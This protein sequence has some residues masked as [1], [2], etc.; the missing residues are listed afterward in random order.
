MLVLSAWLNAQTTVRGYVFLDKNGNGIKDYG[1]KG[2]KDILVSNQEEIVSTD[3]SGKYEINVAGNPYVFVIKPV[4]Y[5][6]SSNWAESFYVNAQNSG[7]NYNFGLL[8]TKI[9]KKFTALFVG[10]PQMRGEKALNAFQ[11]DIVTEMLNYDVKFACFLGDI[12]DNDLSIYPKEKDIVKQLPYPSLHLFGNHDIAEKATTAENAADIFK[13]YYGPDYYSFDEGNVH[14]IVLNNILYKGWDSE[15]NKRGD[16]FGGLTNREYQWLKADLKYVD[17][18][19]LI[20]IQSHIPFREE[21]CYPQEIQR[22]FGLLKGRKHL[23]ALSGH[24]H[25][26]RNDFFNNQ[27]FWNSSSEFQ[28]ITIGAACGGW[29]TGPMDERGLPVA[30]CADGSPN[31]YYRFTFEGNK[32]RYE[33]VPADHRSDFQMR[34]TLSDKEL[35]MGKLQGIYLSINI[36]TATCKAS[37]KVTFDDKKTIF[38]KNYT[39]IDLFMQQTHSLRYNFDNWQPK[40]EKTSHLWKVLL[41][42]NLSVGI[43]KI[44]V[45]AEDKD[46]NRYTGY[47]IIEIKNK[48]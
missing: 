5:T 45:E 44:K 36:F 48:E 43:H 8:K 13:S 26:I 9:D 17:N 24:L 7:K 15:N 1:E 31:G 19:K 46:G 27:S 2:I 23:L 35:T 16:Y 18:E 25:T 4:D 12:A 11:D 38:A 6:F 22:L 40:L 34:L 33:F 37:V 3:A 32:Y 29:W 20:V 10:D 28:D 47:K 14:F 42:E 21:Y 30:T 39:G 41:P